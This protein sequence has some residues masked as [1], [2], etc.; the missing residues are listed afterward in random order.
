VSH[1][2]P[3]REKGNDRKMAD[4]KMPGHP[5]LHPIFLSVIFLSSPLRASR[6]RVRICLVWRQRL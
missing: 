3:P 6:L 4:R 2:K 5:Q 1:A